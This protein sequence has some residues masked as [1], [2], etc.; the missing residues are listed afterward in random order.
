[1]WVNVLSF[2]CF[3]EDYVAE[4]T[5]KADARMTVLTICCHVSQNPDKVEFETVQKQDLGWNRNRGFLEKP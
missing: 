2:T 1:M 3:R 4:F 5:G